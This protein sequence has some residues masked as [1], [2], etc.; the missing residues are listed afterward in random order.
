MK[1]IAATVCLLFATSLLQAQTPAT[2]ATPATPDTKAPAAK[3]TT[4]GKAAPGKTDDKKKEELPKIP[5]VTLTR[6]D[7]NLLGLEIADGNF[8][9]SFYDKKHKP[10]AP[11][12]T[13]ATARWPNPRSVTGPNRTVLN[14]S[15]MALIGQKPVLPPY[16]FSVHLILLRGDGDDAAVVE[17]YDVVPQG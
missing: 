11:D 9:L 13:R 12:V 4:P 1:S 17:S 14:P 6:P 5:G 16:T 8:K 7:G 2:P 3:D 10:L 15:D